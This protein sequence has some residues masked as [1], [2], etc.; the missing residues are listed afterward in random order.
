MDYTKDYYRILGV[1]PDSD[2]AAIRAAYKSLM[3]KYHPGQN[4]S[5]EAPGITKSLTEALSILDN[6]VCRLKYDQ[7]RLKS[8]RYWSD[9]SGSKMSTLNRS[10]TTRPIDSALNADPTYRSRT[11]LGVGGLLIT[12]TL[13]ALAVATVSR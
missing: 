13:M 10:Y 4:R 6:E 12:L 5:A 1:T 11:I 3:I 2:S 7:Y 8:R 9:S